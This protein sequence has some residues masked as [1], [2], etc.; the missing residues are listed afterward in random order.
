MVTVK[1]NEF[2]LSYDDSPEAKERAWSMLLAYYQKHR[3]FD[4]E[5][6]YQRDAPQID[7]APTL[8]KLAEKAFRFKVKWHDDE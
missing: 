3:T 1:G 6:I 7:A 2:D 5:S 8:V 4:G